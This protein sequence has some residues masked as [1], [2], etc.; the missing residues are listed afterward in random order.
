MKRLTLKFSSSLVVLAIC[1]LVAFTPNRGY[2]QRDEELPLVPYANKFSLGVGVGIAN[3]WG[4]LNQHPATLGVRLGVGKHVTN[5][6]IVGLEVY[7]GTLTS[8]ET[9]N[10]W[11]TGISSASSFVAVDL[12][13]KVNLSVFFSNVD[14]GLT[15]VL[16]SFYIGSG[17]GYID[18]NITSI[19]EKLKPKDTTLKNAIQKHA[20]VPYLPLNIGCRVPFKHFLGTHHT[21]LMV[22]MNMCYTYSDYIDGYNLSKVGKIANATNRFNDVYSICTVGLSFSLAKNKN[23]FHIFKHGAD[24]KTPAAK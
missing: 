3:M 19:S 5:S 16:S 14:N 8:K 2:C 21:S 18:N 6:L 20:S 1:G 15:R 22:N 13:A 11:N 23:S 12:N 4:D 24:D 17:I 10:S 7:Q 9:P